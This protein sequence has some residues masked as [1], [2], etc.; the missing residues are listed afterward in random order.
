MD[1]SRDFLI[2]IARRYYIDEKSQQEIA[3]EFGLSRPTVSNILKKCKETGIV[4]IRVQD[5][6]PRTT[7]LGEEVRKR[8]G[9]SHVLVIPSTL[10]DMSVLSR[11][12]SEAAK[13]THSMLRSGLQIGVAWGYHALPGGPSDASGTAVRAGEGGAA[14]GWVRFFESAV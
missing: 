14:H 7:A 2:S 6:S 10:D 9:L 11:V 12:G 3:R 13:F 5:G 1:R 4:E 8:Y